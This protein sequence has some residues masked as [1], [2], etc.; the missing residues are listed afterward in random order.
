MAN[1]ANTSQSLCNEFFG[2]IPLYLLKMFFIGPRL[3]FFLQVLFVLSCAALVNELIFLEVPLGGKFLERKH[4]IT[5]LGHQVTV[6]S[7]LSV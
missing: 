5:S 4:K 1:N 2:K 6:F 7:G 3:E